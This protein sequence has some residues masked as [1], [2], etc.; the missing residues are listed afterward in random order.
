VILIVSLISTKSLTQD[1]IPNNLVLDE[2]ELVVV[3][4][5]KYAAF[6]ADQYS[7]VLKLYTFYQLYIDQKIMYEETVATYED[8]LG[9]L[10]EK[11]RLKQLTIESLTEDREL[12]YD[13]I[14]V[15]SDRLE[16]QQRKEKVKIFVW[17]GLGVIVGGGLGVLIYALAK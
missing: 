14:E 17:T 16:S 13:Q 9:L 11:I 8:E 4:N 12:A 15:L 5:T 7:I 6:T 1:E 10:G 2:P 3:N